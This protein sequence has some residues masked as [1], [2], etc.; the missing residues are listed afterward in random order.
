[1]IPNALYTKAHSLLWMDSLWHTKN[2]YDPIH[3]TNPQTLMI[4]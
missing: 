3:A 2:G 1:M 4:E